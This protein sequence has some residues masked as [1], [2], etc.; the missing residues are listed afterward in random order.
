MKSVSDIQK[1]ILEDE[2]SI[3][4]ELLATTIVSQT[5]PSAAAAV[6]SV[7]A[8]HAIAEGATLAHAVDKLQT[9]DDEVVRAVRDL[10]LARIDEEERAAPD[11]QQQEGTREQLYGLHLSGGWFGR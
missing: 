8:L 11:T 3:Q 7:Y 6:G 10:Y 2:A 1:A 4:P 9:D 5:L